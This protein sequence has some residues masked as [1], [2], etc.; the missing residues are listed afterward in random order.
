MA[1]ILDRLYRHSST[2]ERRA[3]V[4]ILRLGKRALPELLRAAAHH[5]NAFARSVAVGALASHGT[6][7]RRAVFLALRDPAMP[8]RLAALVALDR[9]WTRSAAPAVT[10]LLQDPSGGVRVNAAAVLARHR[11][12]AAWRPL[13][14]LLRD[15]KWYVRLEAARALGRLGVAA[16]R[17]PLA[18]AQRDPSPAVRAAA[19]EAIERL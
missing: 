10:S 17:R 6:R 7:G 4:H 2:A 13:T 19:G 14:R 16:A 1:A 8:V 3:G 18:R 5:P 15:G 9:V 11:V 12:R